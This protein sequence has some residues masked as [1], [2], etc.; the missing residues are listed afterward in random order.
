MEKMSGARMLVEALKVNRVKYLIGIHGI[1]TLPV[2]DVLYDE[3]SIQNITVRH[4]EASPFIGSGYAKV[5]GGPA[6]VFSI[7]GP[8]AT[9]MVTS[10]ASCYEDSVPLVAISAAIPPARRHL[11]VSHKCDL[12]PIFRPITKEV[13]ECAEVGD[14]PAAVNRAF[15]VATEGRNGPVMVLI[16]ANLFTATG[17]A[18]IKPYEPDPWQP[19]PSLEAQLKAATELL[20]KAQAPIIFA[21]SGLAMAGATAELKQLAEKL[22]APV[23]TSMM[24]R[25]GISEEHPLSAGTFLLEGSAGMVAQADTCLALGTRFS[26]F[27]CRGWNVKLPEAL[28]EVNISDDSMG[29]AY[30]PKVAL[31]ADARYVLQK[32]LAV[33]PSKPPNALMMTT[34]RQARKKY[35]AEVEALMQQ[36]PSFPLHPRWLLR[37]LRECLSPETVVINDTN[38][39][40]GWVHEHFFTVYQPRT[41]ISNDGFGSMGYPLPA[42][43]GVK[44]ADPARQVVCLVG[45]GS[46]LMQLSELATAAAYGLTVPVIVFNDGHYG[47]LWQNQ[48][49]VY[50]QRFLG[51]DLTNPDFVKIAEGFGAAGVRISS[52]GEL[53]PAVTEALARKG[54]TVIDVPVDDRPVGRVLWAKFVQAGLIPAEDKSLL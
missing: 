22:S 14:I 40:T 21:G 49:H 7:Q 43:I 32:L 8:G 13:I 25:G 19:T 10:V 6:V 20:E 4:E 18:G 3:P 33:L 34:L 28:V 5:D 46:F 51:T 48:K 42:G 12:A 45:D 52:P 30:K 37:T 26:E 16:P 29:A 54:P 35:R 24:G 47:V 17:E 31:V 50:R 1:G 2:L 27:D 53:A 9:N 15:R 44:L 39:L 41:L 38:M 23:F 11:S 36:K